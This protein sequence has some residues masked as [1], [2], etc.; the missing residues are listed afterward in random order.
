MLVTI[1][2][3]TRSILSKL[4]H[5]TSAPWWFC[6]KMF[7]SA[8]PGRNNTRE[9]PKMYLMYANGLGPFGTARTA[10]AAAIANVTVAQYHRVLINRCLFVVEIGFVSMSF[11]FSTFKHHCTTLLLSQLNHISLFC[12][13]LSL[14]HSFMLFI[15][16][17]FELQLSSIVFLKISYNLSATNFGCLFRSPHVRSKQVYRVTLHSHKDN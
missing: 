2:K 10:K 11:S 12:C 17:S 5:G 4:P 1:D 14:D 15:K 7:M 8:N 6:Q 13:L 3:I 16:T 9:R